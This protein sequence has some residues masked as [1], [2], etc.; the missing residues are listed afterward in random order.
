MSDVEVSEIQGP[1]SGLLVQCSK[2][3][4]DVD[5]S[6][7]TNEFPIEELEVARYTPT[8]ARCHTEAVGYAA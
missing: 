4:I 8:E 6:D 7:W 2:T 3:L 1:C 5:Q